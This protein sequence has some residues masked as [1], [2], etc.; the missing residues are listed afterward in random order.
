MKYI[1][2]RPDHIV[3]WEGNLLS[4][5]ER[6]IHL[7]HARELL[8]LTLPEM[9]RKF[10]RFTVDTWL[11]FEFNQAPLPREILGRVESSLK[12]KGRHIGRD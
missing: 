7:C 4:Y 12:R 5:K 11:V 8:G 2:L 1:A 10:G 9:A 3:V 6:Q